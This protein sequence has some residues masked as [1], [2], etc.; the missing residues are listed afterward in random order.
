MKISIKVGNQSNPE[1]HI[2]LTDPSVS[3]E[4][5]EI[6]L[7]NGSSM[8]VKDTNSTYGSFVNG[9]RI[10]SKLVEENDIITFGHTPFSGNELL[11]ECQKVLTGDKV[12]WEKEFNMLA[13][14]FERYKSKKKQLKSRHNIKMGITRVAVFALFFLSFSFIFQY[15][16]VDPTF[17]TV[18]IIGASMAAALVAGV[19]VSQEKLKEN[20]QKVDEEFEDILTCPNPQCRFKLRS[21]SFRYWRKK[22]KCPK[23]LSIW[24]VH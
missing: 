11:L 16:G 15:V 2:K 13:N 21:R 20:L 10:I 19:F 22:R 12:H 24:L 18:V 3:K 23:C 14:D 9:R 7:I 1:N 17:R 5:A 6:E 8:I 4:H